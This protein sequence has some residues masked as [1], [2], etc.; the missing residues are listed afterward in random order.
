[1]PIICALWVKGHQQSTTE[2][3]NELSL[4]KMNKSL[5]FQCKEMWS[6][7]SSAISECHLSLCNISLLLKIKI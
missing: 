3:Y 4:F 2:Y 7:E 1:M 5:M 6:F